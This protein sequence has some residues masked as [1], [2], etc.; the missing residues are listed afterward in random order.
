MCADRRYSTEAAALLASYA[1]LAAALVRAGLAHR[2]RTNVGSNSFRRK[3]TLDHVLDRQALVGDILL[4]LEH[5]LVR[6]HELDLS[7]VREEFP[8]C[9]E[10]QFSRRFCASR[11]MPMC[12]HG[13]TLVAIVL[14]LA[15]ASSGEDLYAARAQRKRR[16]KLSV[17]RSVLPPSRAFACVA[18]DFVLR[19]CVCV[20]CC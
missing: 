20:S 8:F 9:L 4:H 17:L 2:R 19:A 6:A 3:R 16:E 13:L 18:V 10:R 15:A 11:P 14:L 12:H 1:R 7:F 5:L